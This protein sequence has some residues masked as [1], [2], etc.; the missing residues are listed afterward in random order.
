MFVKINLKKTVK[1][2]QLETQEEKS[3]EIGGGSQT[4]VTCNK[5]PFWKRVQKF[6]TRIT[7]VLLILRTVSQFGLLP[8]E[9]KEA[10]MDPKPTI[11]ISINSAKDPQ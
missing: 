2:G 4:Q 8:E 1:N 10:V 11:E 3:I 7:L 5:V 6:R 9:V